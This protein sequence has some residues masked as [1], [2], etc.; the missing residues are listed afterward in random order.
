MAP[1][2]VFVTCVACGGPPSVTQMPPTPAGPRL[3]TDSEER[4]LALEERMRGAS[5]VELAFEISSTGAVETA[6]AGNLVWARG[7]QI[8]L[9]ATGTFMGAPQDL[10]WRGDAE[11][12]ATF[13]DGEQA[14]QGPRP[15]ALIDAVVVGFT[16]QGLLHNLA[17]L[18]TGG[19]PDRADGFA[20]DWLTIHDVEATAEDSVV[21]GIRYEGESVGVGELFFDADGVPTERRQTV[22]FPEG[23]ME[24]V[25]RYPSFTIEP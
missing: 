8:E 16:R 15:A 12:L 22:Y 11:A 5:R 23:A 17:V 3:R 25:E 21:F 20:G 10:A 9:E 14:W 6:L 18:T 24:V 2:L 13:V 7:D 4:I 1:S 19:P